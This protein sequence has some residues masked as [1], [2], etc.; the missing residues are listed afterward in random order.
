MGPKVFAGTGSNNASCMVCHTPIECT[1][2]EYEISLDG[3]GTV[4][5]HLHCY[6]FWRSESDGQTGRSEN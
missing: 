5:A 1:Q 3:N 4:A 6:Y 2:V